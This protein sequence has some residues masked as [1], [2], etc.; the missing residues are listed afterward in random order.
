MDCPVIED[1]V[2]GEGN[3]YGELV[4]VFFAS[5]DRLVNNSFAIDVRGTRCGRPF[6]D[7]SEGIVHQLFFKSNSSHFALVTSCFL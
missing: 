2:L 5:S 6:L 3:R 1:V 7:R 4:A